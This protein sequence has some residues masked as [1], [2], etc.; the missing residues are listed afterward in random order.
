M[1]Y[2]RTTTSTTYLFLLAP[3]TGNIGGLVFV[4]QNY[5]TDNQSIAK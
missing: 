1:K 2:N 4:C 5:L 3:D